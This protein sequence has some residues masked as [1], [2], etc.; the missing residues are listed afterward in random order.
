[1]PATAAVNK[2]NFKKVYSKD[3]PCPAEHADETQFLKQQ[4]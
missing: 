2:K 4:Q 1:M 3:S